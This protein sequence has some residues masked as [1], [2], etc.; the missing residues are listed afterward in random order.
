MPRPALDASSGTADVGD[1]QDHSRRQA[2]CGLVTQWLTSFRTGRRFSAASSTEEVLVEGHAGGSDEAEIGGE[3]QR[4]AAAADLTVAEAAGPGTL[5][6]PGAVGEPGTIVAAGPA[7]GAEGEAVRLHGE[8]PVRGS[9][10]VS[11]SPI[12]YGRFGRMFRRLP[13]MAPLPNDELLRLSETMREPSAPSGWDGSVQD[14]DNPEIAAGYTYLGQFIDHDITFD[15]TSTLERE[16]D[17]DALV[18]FRSPRFDLDSIYGSGPVDEPFQYKRGT[19]GMRMLFGPN[20]RGEVDLPRNEE[21]TA[22]IGDPRNDENTIVSQLQLLFLRLHDKFAA[23]VESDAAVPEE[24]RFAEAQR[25]V[26]WHYQW[27]IAHD[28]VPRIIGPDTFGEI[29]DVAGGRIVNIKRRHYR[30]RTAAYMPLEFS[31]AAYRYGH[32]QVRGIYNLSDGVRDRPIFLPG[33]L[34]DEKQDLRGFRPLPQGWTV[35][36]PMFFP[37][38][39]STA[40]PSRLI[41]AKLVQGLFDL[42]D[43][44]GSLAFR[45]LKR[46]QVLGLPSGQDVAKALQVER[47]FTGAELTAPEPTPLWFYVLKES[48]LVASGRHLGPVGGRIVGEVL[49]GLLELDPRSWFSLEPSWVPTI[50]DADGD[51]TITMPDLVKFAIG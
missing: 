37:I 20:T 11:R 47:V 8:V 12:D 22:L 26:R 24:L 13:P 40:Q 10:R 30:P 48:E 2:D 41:D 34:Q 1:Y 50:P 46:G 31:A 19:T 3:A 25:R 32:S 7:A 51:G 42:P 49:L 36:W 33:P 18:N 28:F 17:P 21:G 4:Q 15:P 29:C 27:V 16:N 6:E 43:G 35:S 23:E 39:G 45:N 5:A 38:D 14:F 44:G 9:K